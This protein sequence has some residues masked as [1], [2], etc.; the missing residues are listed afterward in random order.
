[1]KTIEPAFGVNLN[2]PAFTEDRWVSPLNFSPEVQNQINAPK[3]VLIHDVTLRDGEQTARI[4]FTPEE[5]IA[6]AV[7]LDKLGVHSI[8]PG[9]PVTAEDQEVIKTL[10]A[11]NLRANIVPLARV[12]E[13]DV[14]NAIDA[15]ADGMVLEMCLNPYLIRDVFKTN[16]DDLIEKIAEFAR[17]GRDAGMYVEYMAWDV[18]RIEGMEFPERFFRRLVERADLDRVT[19]ADTFGM[20]HPFTTY[21]YISKLKEWT[22]KPIGYHIHND[23]GMATANA[24]MAVSAGADEVHGSVNGLGERSGNLA[25]EEISLALQHLLNID[26]GID[27]TRLKPL[28]DMV[29]EISK[30]KPALNKAVVGDGLFEVESGIVI[31]V[32]EKVKGTPLK[33]IALPFSPEVVGQKPSQVIFGVGSGG[34]AVAALLKK[35]GIDASTDQL[36]EIT[37][38]IKTKGRLLKNGVPETVIRQIVD[39][40]IGQPSA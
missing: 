38:Q 7:E 12:N 32:M 33:N 11:M 13:L 25:T 28:S 8:E 26:A 14:R 10:S 4:A 5:K 29:T 1:M 6:I 9:L 20:G 23:Y 18:M 19:V 22:G 35:W 17:A 36:T 30:A 3:Q 34:I 37:A 39:D 2:E 15:K 24:V 40:C 16:P 31:G 21:N 27:L